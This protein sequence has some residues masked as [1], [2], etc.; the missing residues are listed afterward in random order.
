MLELGRNTITMDG[1][2]AFADHAYPNQLGFLE[3]ELTANHI[4]WSIVTEVE[5]H[6]S[7]SGPDGWQCQET[8]CF[9]KARRDA[10]QWQLRFSTLDARMITYQCSYRLKDGSRYRLEPVT[11]GATK[12]NVPNPFYRIP[13]E[14]T[15]L[16]EP[17]EVRLIFVDVQY[18]DPENDHIAHARLR[19]AGNSL[20]ST[21]TTLNI[22]D[23]TQR[24]FRYRISHIDNDDTLIRGPYIETKATLIGVD[25]F[26]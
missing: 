2:T 4:D 22:V 15:P 9:T 23:P 8:F 7:Y 5:I 17:G 18:T 10:Q 26:Q 25:P 11:T 16:Y 1:M 21:W 14:F 12:I 20:D 13:I 24:T 19:L 3:V 6:L